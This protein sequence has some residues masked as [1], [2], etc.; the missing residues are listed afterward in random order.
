M[1]LKV[2][3]TTHFLERIG[4]RKFDLSLVGDILKEL[5]QNPNRNL[6]EISKGNATFVVQFDKVKGEV[7]LVTGWI[8]NRQGEKQKRVIIRD[9]RC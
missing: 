8:G 6:F 1:H 9:K 4:E 5:S 2:I 3:A 7:K